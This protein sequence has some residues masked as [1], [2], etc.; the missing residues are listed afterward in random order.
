MTTCRTC[1]DVTHID[2]PTGREKCNGCERAPL[3]CRCEPVQRAHVPVWLQRAQERP[4]GLARDMT[5]VAA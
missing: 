2:F 1:G 4:S 5:G 3:F